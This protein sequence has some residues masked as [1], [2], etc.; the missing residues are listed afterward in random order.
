MH[1]EGVTTKPTLALKTDCLI[2]LVDST[3]IG[4]V[5]KPTNTW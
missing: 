2:C 4:W 3:H 5:T 1:P